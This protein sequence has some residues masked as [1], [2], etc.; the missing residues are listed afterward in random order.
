MYTLGLEHA[1][2][3]RLA[4]SAKLLEVLLLVLI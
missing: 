1:T 3:A 2:F 4:V